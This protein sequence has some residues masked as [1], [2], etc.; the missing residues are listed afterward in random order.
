VNVEIEQSF[1][2]QKKRVG[3]IIHRIV[4]SEWEGKKI[5]R[6]FKKLKDDQ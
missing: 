3:E 6:T 1:S 4:F 5:P 2:A